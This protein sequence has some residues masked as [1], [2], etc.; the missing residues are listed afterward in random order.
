[1]KIFNLSLL[2]TGFTFSFSLAFAST[3]EFG[4]GGNAL[5]CSSSQDGL[6]FQQ[7]F[8]YDTY[9]AQIR[10]QMNPQ[11][12][13]AQECDVDE[14]GHQGWEDCTNNSA[15]NLASQIVARLKK[16]DAP[17]ESQLQGYIRSF[18]NDARLIDGNLLPVADTGIGFTPADCTLTQVVIQHAPIAAED[19]RYFIATSVLSGLDVSNRAALI[20][21]EVLYRAALIKNPTLPSS[22]SVRYFN[23]VLL[24]DKIS[25]ITAKDY[26]LI[27]HIFIG[28]P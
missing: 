6:S 8:F 28:L 4:N 9:E 12:P 1:M 24:S 18:W 3:T 27:K 17:L 15:Q 22:E 11:F 14:L 23:A 2:L 19:R 7:S 26:E 5:S 25:S 16:I 13:M 10:Y 21:H 20:V